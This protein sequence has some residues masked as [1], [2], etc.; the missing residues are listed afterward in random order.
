MRESGRERERKKHPPAWSVLVL[1]SENWSKPYH[2]DFGDEIKAGGPF[3][4]SQQSGEGMVMSCR[5]AIILGPLID[6]GSLGRANP[7]WI[8]PHP[9]G[10]C[11][12][13]PCPCPLQA[14]AQETC[15]LPMRQ[16]CNYCYSVSRRQGKA[17]QG[18]L[19]PRMRTVGGG[20][21]MCRGLANDHESTTPTRAFGGKLDF[22]D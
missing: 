10:C 3:I 15:R 12:Q 5:G 21:G 11:F 17:R 18:I 19:I 22:H 1:V 2:S 13:G 16:C 8:S 4:E 20:V 9:V 6:R 7:P 14:P